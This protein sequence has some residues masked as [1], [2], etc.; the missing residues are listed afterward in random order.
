MTTYCVTWPDIEISLQ[1]KEHWFKENEY[2]KFE[3]FEFNL[4]TMET[5]RTVLLENMYMEFPN[6]NQ[7]YYGYKCRYTYVAFRTLAEPMSSDK[8]D[9]DNFLYTGFFKYDMQEDRMI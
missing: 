6:L 5:K 9:N 4:T 3:K 1:Y 7:E 8:A 2:Q